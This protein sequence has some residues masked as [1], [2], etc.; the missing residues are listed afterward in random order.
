MKDQI[1]MTCVLAF[2]FLNFF[3]EFIANKYTVQNRAVINF[4][5]YLT[6]IHFLWKWQYMCVKFA[7]KLS[8]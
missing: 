2:F 7:F 8:A 5:Y 1:Y 6:L 3:N 4:H